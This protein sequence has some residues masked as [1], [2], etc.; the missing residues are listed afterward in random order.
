MP[1]DTHLLQITSSMVLLLI[2]VMFVMVVRLLMHRRKRAYVHLMAALAILA[3]YY[4]V[5]LFIGTYPASLS[6]QT[7]LESTR[8]VSFIL[9]LMSLYQLYRGMSRRQA[10]WCYGLALMSVVSNVLSLLGPGIRF[11]GIAGEL[12]LIVIGITGL[13]LLQKE[14]GHK[15]WLY[16]I[17][18]S[19]IAEEIIRAVFEAGD[20]WTL[21]YTLFVFAAFLP[22][23]FAFSLCLSLFMRVMELLTSV[24]QA[25]V[26]DGMTG[27]Y[28][29]KFLMNQ[30]AAAIA[31]KE[32][33]AVIFCDIG[34]FKKLNDTKGHHMGDA[35]LKLVALI[36]KE[37][38][39]GIGSAGR[40][41]GEELVVA[42]FDPYVK[43]IELAERIRRRIER[44]SIVTA[45]I[46]YSSHMEG[47]SVE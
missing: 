20:T 34:N 24:T 7:V 2:A 36:L 25:S 3:T 47:V 22:V 4:F 19:F 26:T 32:L 12:Y 5:L 23:L 9:V 6:V 39:E 11:I 30:M 46:G 1:V 35:M 13:L 18:G 14:L 44:E 21:P 45:S 15:A 41:G 8:S 10:F 42:V 28:N 37:E 43:L 33:V 40:F 31:R 38:S 17:I 27:L 29:R 16:T